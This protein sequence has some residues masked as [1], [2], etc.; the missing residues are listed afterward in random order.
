MSIVGSVLTFLGFLP[1][2]WKWF[3]DFQA[4]QREISFLNYLQKSKDTYAKLEKAKG[5][6]EL[7]NAAIEIQRL[8]HGK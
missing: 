2:L 3:Q 8:M 1:E 5:K 6:E 7:I 4:E